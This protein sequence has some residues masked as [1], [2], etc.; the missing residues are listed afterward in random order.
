VVANVMHFVA[1]D[2]IRRRDDGYRRMQEDRMRGL[3]RALKRGAPQDELRRFSFLSDDWP[4]RE[5]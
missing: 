1:D 3:I 4:R 2:D 5:P